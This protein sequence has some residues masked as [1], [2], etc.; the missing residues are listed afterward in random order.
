MGQFFLVIST[1]TFCELQAF[2]NPA[3]L[4]TFRKGE[5]ENTD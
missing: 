3:T 4:E 1:D 2:T 5:A